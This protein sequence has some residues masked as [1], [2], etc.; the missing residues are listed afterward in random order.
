MRSIWLRYTVGYSLVSML[1]CH[2]NL[3]A[4]LLSVM[5][6]ACGGGGSSSSV[7]PPAVAVSVVPTS[8]SVA[9][10]SSKAFSATVANSG[11]TSVTW[12][13]NGATGGNTT[14]GTISASGVYAAP[15]SMPSAATVSVMAVSEA[16]TTRTAAATVTI[17][18]ALAP[19]APTGLTI[20]NITTGSLMLSW[21]GSTGVDVTGYIVE[22]CSGASCTSFEQIGTA[23]TTTYTDT[24]VAASTAYSYRVRAIDAAGDLSAYSS[25]ASVTTSSGSGQTNSSGGSSSSGSRDRK[26]VV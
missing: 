20:L 16:D 21:I 8:A 18:P 7:A 19:T 12:Q 24:G 26:S 1:R 13:V 17:T 3:G 10:G 2:R 6:A 9:I 5:I 25:I 23:A 15:A 11:N 4:L 14:V 22:H